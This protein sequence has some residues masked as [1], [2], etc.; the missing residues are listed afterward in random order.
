MRWGDVYYLFDG[1]VYAEHTHAY[2]PSIDFVRLLRVCLR[3][4]AFHERGPGAVVDLAVLE[5]SD[6]AH[7]AGYCRRLETVAY[8]NCL[9]LTFIWFWGISDKLKR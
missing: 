9:N 1:G 4:L 5:A 2:A 3:A 6:P 8:C 7:V